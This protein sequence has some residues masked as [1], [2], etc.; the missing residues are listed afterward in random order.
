MKLDVK[1]I[2]CPKSYSLD[3]R[4]LS[5]QFLFLLECKISGWRY[6]KL[7]QE[8]FVLQS[9]RTLSRSTWGKSNCFHFL[10]IFIWRRNRLSAL[11]LVSQCEMAQV[12]HGVRFRMLTRSLCCVLRERR[13]IP[14][15]LPATRASHRF[16]FWVEPP[17][18]PR[19]D[20]RLSLTMVLWHAHEI[21]SP[22]KDDP[23]TGKWQ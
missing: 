23:L 6:L 9:S 4:S 2:P 12:L 21:M 7:S 19:R 11:L 17:S 1:N 18:P 3:N 13:F 15:V 10:S 8:N 20:Y 16:S 22:L 5:N 14:E